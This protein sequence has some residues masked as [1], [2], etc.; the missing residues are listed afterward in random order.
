MLIGQ[1]TV[2]KGCRVRNVSQQG[3]LLQCKPDGR[4]LTFNKGD[5]VEI[6]LKVQYAG[7][8]KSLTIPSSVRHVNEAYIYV[9]FQHPD[10][11]LVELIESYR[12]SEAHELEASVDYED[13]RPAVS[14]VSEITDTETTMQADATQL[15]EKKGKHRSFYHG[16]LTLILAICIITG[17]YIY[18]N[19]VDNRL[20][21]LETI[22]DRQTAEL[23][24]MREQLFSSTLQ[25]GRYASLNVRM[26]AL[27]EA[28]SS[29]ENKLTQLISQ[30][31]PDTQGQ[32]RPAA[33]GDTPIRITSKVAQ[34]NT[35][36]APTQSV[37]YVTASLAE[38]AEPP[39]AGPEVNTATIAE[40]AILQ[41][42]L[43]D[44]EPAAE[45]GAAA[46]ETASETMATQAT[47]TSQEP[48]I[49]APIELAAPTKQ[50]P[51][52]IN[53]MSSTDKRYVE[54]HAAQARSR[55][56]AVEV[57]NAEVKGRTYWRMQIS[58]FSSARVARAEAAAVK[59][60]LGINDVWIFRE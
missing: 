49:E 30:R 25:E 58:G 54:Q 3:M 51:W 28:F 10:L 27:T 8:K 33:T 1:K 40:T 11:K 43:S 2:P 29:L 26:T 56:V 47:D 24:N 5:K 6:H 37:A 50:G 13:A 39:L 32:T 57:N 60:K 18:S 48:S 55:N 19:S 22:T 14:R 34:K 42:V 15:P 44:A 21:M 59:E 36:L 9:E 4:L 35:T 38:Q 46:E 17:G 53:L 20:G 23:D 12:A 16:L 7:E 45:T 41:Q 31:M 52:V